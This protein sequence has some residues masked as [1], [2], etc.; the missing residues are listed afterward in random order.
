MRTSSALA[1]LL[2]LAGCS[3][4]RDAS[5]Q[6]SGSPKA[7]GASVADA[8][9]V[10]CALDGALAFDDG[11]TLE[12]A[13]AEGAPVVIIRHADG[14]FRRF[15]ILPDGSLGE[16]DGAQKAVINRDGGTIEV[17]VGADRYRIEAGRLGNGQ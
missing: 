14:G 13:Q 1:G 11:C 16:A 3:S 6:G 10:A 2:L 5:E 17:S 7:A 4:E 8:D 15:A 9:R 12:Q